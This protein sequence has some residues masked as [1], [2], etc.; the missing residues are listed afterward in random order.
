MA[1]FKAEINDAVRNPGL[2]QS[3]A[4]DKAENTHESERNLNSEG[5][6]PAGHS[7]ELGKAQQKASMFT[8]L[9]LLVLLL[10]FSIPIAGLLQSKED[11]PD[12]K[13]SSGQESSQIPKSN[14]SNQSNQKAQSEAATRSLAANENRLRSSSESN[15]GK[16]DSR[17][18]NSQVPVASDG[19]TKPAA[20]TTPAPTSS[21]TAASTAPGTDSSPK[22]TATTKVTA[23]ADAAT[24]SSAADTSAKSDLQASSTQRD[25]Q[26][27]EIEK[28]L[29]KEKKT[30]LKLSREFKDQAMHAYKSKNLPLAVKFLKQALKQEELVYSQQDARLIPTLS[31]LVGCL[32][33]I[34]P[35]SQESASYLDAALKCYD[36]DRD[37]ASSLPAKAPVSIWKPLAY[38]SLALALRERGPRKRSYGQW[39]CLFFEL[40]LKSSK[41]S[42][43]DTEYYTMLNAYLSAALQAGELDQVRKLKAELIEAGR[44]ESA[45]AGD[46]RAL[47][48]KQVPDISGP[49]RQHFFDRGRKGVDLLKRRMNQPRRQFQN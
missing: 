28:D 29:S 31:M 38:E 21:R 45:F 41:Q 40:A 16:K 6:T 42:G 20:T 9:V 22:R 34:S 35:D 33:Q 48:S 11:K 13:S 1:A 23:S 19:N 12:R 7:K 10:S 18:A 37:R 17:T 5:N 4:G 44:L 26:I 32:R 25:P 2:A 49:R 15:L 3:M 47:P 27:K 14:P 39:S 30:A 36:A 8:M 43:K 46:G 24:R